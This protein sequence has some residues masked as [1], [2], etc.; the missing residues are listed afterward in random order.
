MISYLPD[1]S[2]FLSVHTELIQHLTRSLGESRKLALSFRINS[3][4]PIFEKIIKLLL[5]SAREEP[6]L[7]DEK[8][9]KE[10]KKLKLC[11]CCR[12]SRRLIG[13]ETR[14]GERMFSRQADGSRSAYIRR[15]D[16]NL[17]ANQ[18]HMPASGPHSH[19]V[20]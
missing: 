17:T 20:I 19:L 16:V 12:R 10:K 4:R 14:A 18:H 13:Q 5:E 11:V 8:I 3:K 9:D 15:L 2:F 7:W 1:I 6:R